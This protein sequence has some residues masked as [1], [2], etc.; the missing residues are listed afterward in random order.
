MV[1]DLE[2]ANLRGADLSRANLL[3]ANLSYSELCDTSLSSAT[4]LRTTVQGA[5]IRNANIHGVSV[6]GLKGQPLEQKDL[7][8]TT[9]GEPL[10]T[11]DDIEVGQFV[12]LLI[13]NPKIKNIID[14]LTSKIVLILGNF[15]SERKTVL[16]SLREAL[17]S[18]NLSPIL[19][20][21]DRSPN[22]DISD[23][24]TLLARMARFVIAD[25]SSPKC[26]QQELSMIAG[27]VLVPIRP[28]IVSGQHPWAMFG[29]LQRRSRGLMPILEYADVNDLLRRIP[30]EIIAPAEVCRTQLLN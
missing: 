16:D 14:V 18:Y 19:F 3:D 11:V 28:I 27:Q 9:I 23:T 22:L 12:Y 21:F 17:R 26:V 2:R 6:W 4:L 1:T 10:I 25:L 30:D 24:I 13:H 20:D 29:D 5:I 7:T 15:S 8:I